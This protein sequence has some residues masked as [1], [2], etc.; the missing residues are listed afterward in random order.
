MQFLHM[1]ELTYAFF[2][3]LFKNLFSG[4]LLDKCFENFPHLL[5]V[6]SGSFLQLYLNIWLTLQVF[7]K[8][9]LLGIY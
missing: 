5:S 2:A 6:G 7:G 3:Y 9:R 8:I 1:S 4:H